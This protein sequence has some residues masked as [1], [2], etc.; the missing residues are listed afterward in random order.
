MQLIRGLHHIRLQHQGA[1][2]TIGN[3]DGI[4]RG[5]QTLLHRVKKTADALGAPAGVMI[6][7][8]QPLEFFN[9]EYSVP[10]L[11]RFR[12]K[13]HY[14]SQY[15]LDQVMLVQ[16]TKRFAVLSAEAF[17]DEILYRA[18]R[19]K[20]LILGKD[21]QFGQGRKGNI[22]FLKEMSHHYGL[23]VETIEDVQEYD[24]RISSTLIR[25][26]LVAGDHAK[27]ERLLGRPYSMMGRVVYGDQLG[28]KLGFPTANIYLYRTRTAVH[29]I[30]AVRLY[31]I[32]Q[33]PLL[34]VANVGMRP[35]VGGTR[36]LLEVFIFDFNQTIYG[37]YVRVEFCKKLRDEVRFENL[38]LLKEQMWKDA[39]EARHYFIEQNELVS[40]I[41]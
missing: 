40:E 3:F 22:A 10:R 14:L 39:D 20:H 29:G 35:T 9:Q 2:M 11:T 30:Y 27:A 38:T 16:F 32:T 19:V 12:E 15:N 37:R 36:T 21:F 31:G 34:G 18:L 28:R 1:V 17:V 5:H 7:E 25:D 6:F 4:H 13:W 23:S 41:A 26:A 33:Q 24:E 8:P